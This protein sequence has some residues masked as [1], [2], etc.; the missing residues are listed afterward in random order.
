MEWRFPSWIGNKRIFEEKPIKLGMKKPVPY[1]HFFPTACASKNQMRFNLMP[2]IMIVDDDVITATELIE[3]L[4]SSGYNIAGT[5]ESGKEAI[6]M[7]EKTGR[8][9]F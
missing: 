3:A 9:L 7:A 6:E 2:K 4:H 8:I 1:P 5:A